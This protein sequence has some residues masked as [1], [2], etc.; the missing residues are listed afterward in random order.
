MAVNE[1]LATATPAAPGAPPPRMSDRTSH[2]RRLGLLLSAP[3][4][5]VM[6]LVTAYPL[7]YAVILSLYNYRLTDP[8]GK[9]FVG[10]ANYATVLTDPVWWTDF[11]TTFIITVISVAVELVLGFGF[12]FVM[13]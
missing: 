5:V 3:A 1:H 2:E 7:V 9:E 13:Y 12:A 10:L 11:G 8:A 4:F 6:V